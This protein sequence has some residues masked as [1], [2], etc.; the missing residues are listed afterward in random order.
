MKAAITE[1]SAAT[2]PRPDTADQFDE[3]APQAPTQQDLEAA[4]IA[5]IVQRFA[6]S[7]YMLTHD[8]D[9]F[10]VQ[11]QGCRLGRATNLVELRQLLEEWLGDAA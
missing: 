6:K 10:E 5:V 9:G 1:A 4:E 2:D 7:P 3:L 11:R 8:E